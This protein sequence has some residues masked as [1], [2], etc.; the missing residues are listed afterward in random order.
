MST[1][2]ISKAKV[3]AGALAFRDGGS[4]LRR[5]TTGTT[6]LNPASIAATTRGSV[7]FTLTGAAAGDL[8][9]MQ[10]PADVNDD[11]IFVGAEVTSANTVTVYLY[12]PTVG[13]IDDAATTWRYIW[14][15][16]T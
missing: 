10:P 3:I 8:I 16:L 5:V 6:S 13:A 14:M 9:H 2:Q 11:L 1:N 15:D 4:A 7:T 12:N